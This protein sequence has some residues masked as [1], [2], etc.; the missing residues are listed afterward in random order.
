MLLTCTKTNMKLQQH[1]KAPD[2]QLV[3][4]L[5][6]G[7]VICYIAIAA[8]LYGHRHT[9]SSLLLHSECVGDLNQA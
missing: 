3:A 6:S 7:Q 5:I 1:L 9:H 4:E 2:K 8:V